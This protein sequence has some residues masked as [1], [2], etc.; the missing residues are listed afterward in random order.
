MTPDEAIKR[1]KQLPAT[2]WQSLQV[3]IVSGASAGG[4]VQPAA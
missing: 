2:W 1:M 3:H 4:I